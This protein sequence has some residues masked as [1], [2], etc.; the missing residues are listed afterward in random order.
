[1]ALRMDAYVALMRQEMAKRQPTSA[2]LPPVLPV[3]VYTGDR[4]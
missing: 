3:L 2:G 4:P 1:M